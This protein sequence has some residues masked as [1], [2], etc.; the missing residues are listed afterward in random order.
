M[1]L[2][3][4]LNLVPSFEKGRDDRTNFFL[5]FMHRA[6]VINHIG[7]VVMETGDD[8]VHIHC[9][10][11]IHIR[12]NN[13]LVV[14]LDCRG[15]FIGRCA[16]KM[17]PSLSLTRGPRCTAHQGCSCGAARSEQASAIHL[18]LRFYPIKIDQR[19]IKPPLKLLI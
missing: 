8:L 4:R 15:N 5:A 2:T 16:E 10:P 17:F 7:N 12:Q 14:A 13:G 11:A 19:H 6:A 9:G 18:H 1:R 3:S